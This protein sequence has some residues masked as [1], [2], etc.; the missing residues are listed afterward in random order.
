MGLRVKC[1]TLR[2]RFRSSGKQVENLAYTHKCAQQTDP[3][4]MPNS[5]TAF[6][7]HKCTH[8]HE[9]T[10][11]P[12]AD[13]VFR[14]GWSEFI[15]RAGLNI[16][17]SGVMQTYQRPHWEIL[18]SHWL[19]GSEVMG[20]DKGLN[21]QKNINWR[22]YV[23]DNVQSAAHYQHI[24]WHRGIRTLMWNIRVLSQL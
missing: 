10:H 22:S 21:S 13:T 6:H 20:D 14:S 11:M 24:N 3:A 18:G 4:I 7:R 12:Y 5:P 19:G 2:M 16:I 1:I 15:Y 23:R 8:E 17:C 9:F